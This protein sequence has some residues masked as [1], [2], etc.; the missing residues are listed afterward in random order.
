MVRSFGNAGTGVC[1]GAERK[2]RGPFWG[3]FGSAPGQFYSNE[4]IAVDRFGRV[5]VTDYHN[6]RVQKFAF[7]Q[8]LPAASPAGR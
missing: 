3:S 6:Q 1:P 7:A 4:G 2:L 8:T 5:Y